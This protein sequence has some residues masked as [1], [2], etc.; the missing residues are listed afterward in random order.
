MAT[1]WRD[2]SGK[3]SR[4]QRNCILENIRRDIYSKIGVRVALYR[5][6][7][8]YQFF[9]SLA[10]WKSASTLRMFLA[11]KSAVKY[12]SV[13]DVCSIFFNITISRPGKGIPYRK[14]MFS[15]KNTFFV[16]TLPV[17]VLV[18]LLCTCKGEVLYA[19]D[20][21]GGQADPLQV[22]QP[23]QHK[24]LDNMIVGHTH[25]DITI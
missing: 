2:W 4:N 14:K 8:I 1:F 3:L 17:H 21:G 11:P 12:N 22:L 5:Q 23:G 18:S 15:I 20:V 24:H 16:S 19:G 10:A 25:L 7:W 13:P 6:L 9:S